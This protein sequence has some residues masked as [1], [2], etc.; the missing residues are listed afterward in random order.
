VVFVLVRSLPLIYP[1]VDYPG[2]WTIRAADVQHSC[3]RGTL[4]PKA[5]Y[6]HIFVAISAP[7]PDAHGPSVFC[8]APCKGVFASNQFDDELRSMKLEGRGREVECKERRSLAWG[9][10]F[11]FFTAISIIQVVIYLGT[12][13]GDFIYSHETSANCNP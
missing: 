10:L 13:T 3:L 9:F 6:V 1:W 2:F 7:I 12:V 8:S 11:V 4:H 5:I